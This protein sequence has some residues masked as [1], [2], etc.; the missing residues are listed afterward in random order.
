M[1][2]TDNTVTEAFSVRRTSLATFF[3]TSAATLA[4]CEQSLSKNSPEGEEERLCR[5]R[6]ES[7]KSAQPKF[8]G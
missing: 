5:N 8:L 2:V 6:V 7:F 1:F 4:R 3:L